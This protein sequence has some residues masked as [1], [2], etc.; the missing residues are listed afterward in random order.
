M[1][2]EL[3]G[4]STGTPTTATPPTSAAR[5]AQQADP[6]KVAALLLI[7]VLV[8]GLAIYFI[9]QMISSAS[10]GIWGVVGVLIAGVLIFGRLYSR[11]R[12]LL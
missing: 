12:K 8:V 2:D 3:Q 1:A 11:M 9:Q 5:P 10:S 7:G 4:K 6:V